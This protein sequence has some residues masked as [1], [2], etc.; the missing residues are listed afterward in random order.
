MARVRFRTSDNLNSGGYCIYGLLH[1]TNDY[2]SGCTYKMYNGE[3]FNATIVVDNYGHLYPSNYSTI[4][5]TESYYVDFMYPY[6]S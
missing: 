5:R 6:Y 3:E 1:G 4:Y 2:S